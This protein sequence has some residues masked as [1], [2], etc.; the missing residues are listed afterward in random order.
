M[1]KIEINDSTYTMVLDGAGF[2]TADI[3]VMYA[4][5]DTEPTDDDSFTRNPREQVNG[6]GGTKLWAKSVAYSKVAV[7]S[8]GA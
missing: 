7:S 4:F 6:D 1:A 5:G 3:E 8:I 2:V